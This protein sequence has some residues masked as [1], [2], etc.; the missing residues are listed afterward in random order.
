[1][2]KNKSYGIHIVTEGQVITMN[3]TGLKHL[4]SGWLI[5]DNAYCSIYPVV[6]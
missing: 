2:D 4:S 6:K 3:T 5:E 1:M